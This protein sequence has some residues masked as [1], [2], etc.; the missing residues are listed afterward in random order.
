MNDRV[1]YVVWIF[2]GVLFI[3][4]GLVSYF[5]DLVSSVYKIEAIPVLI[6]LK[7]VNY[8]IVSLFTGTKV[9]YRSGHP[10]VYVI[11]LALWIPLMVVSLYLANFFDLAPAQ[12][13]S[14][15]IFDLAL[16]LPILLSLKN[17]KD[18]GFVSGYGVYFDKIKQKWFFM[19]MQGFLL[20]TLLL[21]VS[22]LLS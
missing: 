11:A 12:E 4:Y 9:Y 21:L 17:M 20:F 22:K 7:F 16:Y 10:A 14:F 3:F 13:V 19:L 5:E 6:S 1:L 8:G 2:F 18:C 15:W